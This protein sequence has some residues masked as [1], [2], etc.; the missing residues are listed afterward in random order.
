M[1]SY[2][3]I[4]HTIVGAGGIRCSC[5]N[6]AKYATNRKARTRNRAKRIA[7]KIVRQRLKNI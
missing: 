4:L 3:K 5:C 1:D 7:T 2:T 6:W